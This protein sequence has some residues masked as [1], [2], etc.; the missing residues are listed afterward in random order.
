MTKR[1]NGDLFSDLIT[2]VDSNV[3]NCNDD[4]ATIDRI[5]IHHNAGTDDATARRTWYVSTGAGT[6]AH[7]QITPDK[8]WGCVGEESVA[9]HAGN[10]AMNKRSIGLEHLNNKGAPEWTIAEET[11]KNSAKLIADICSRYSI[12]I[13]RSCILKHSEV[14]D[15]PTQCPGGIDIDKLIS[16]ANDVANG[17]DID[18]SNTTDETKP[19]NTDS[20]DNTATTATS[21]DLN[22]AWRFNDFIFGNVGKSS[23]SDTKSEVDNGQNTG[24]S[25]GTVGQLGGLAGGAVQWCLNSANWNAFTDTGNPGIYVPA[26]GI[27]YGGSYS[28]TYG[29]AQCFQLAAAYIQQMGLDPSIAAGGGNDFPRG[30]SRRS[31]FES[32]GWTVIDNPTF[33]QLSIG[34]ITYETN[35]HT[36]MI[37]SI[38]GNAVTFLSQ[39]TP[40]PG[41]FTV[42]TGG[43]PLGFSNHTIA[44]IAIPPDSLIK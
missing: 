9:F 35:P 34:A 32:H 4:R 11:Y 15:N 13:D 7:Y 30:G 6:S 31:Y 3:M 28:S 22:G 24:G 1:V 43:T 21:T 20:T 16:L 40:S 25:T 19:A 42:D 12:P 37:V 33:S 39:N 2:D 14:S 26:T 29:W 5:I 23:K 36:E 10:Y 18:K 44:A 17:T 41:L 27:D 38:E 8:I